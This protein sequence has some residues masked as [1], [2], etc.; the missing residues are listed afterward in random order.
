LYPLFTVSFDVA[1]FNPRC[2]TAGYQQQQ[3]L[4]FTA[5]DSLAP[6]EYCEVRVAH[7]QLIKQASTVTSVEGSLAVVR[8][9][10]DILRLKDEG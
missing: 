1:V 5:Y 4:G 10:R 3:H 8:I 9:L 6:H 7:C 2:Q